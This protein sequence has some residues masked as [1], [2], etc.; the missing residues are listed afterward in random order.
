[1]GALLIGRVMIENA[2]TID[3]LRCRDRMQS[4]FTFKTKMNQG[5]YNMG[6]LKIKE[7]LGKLSAKELLKLVGKE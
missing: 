7:E 6:Q 1:M 2:Q 4:K 5:A 3:L